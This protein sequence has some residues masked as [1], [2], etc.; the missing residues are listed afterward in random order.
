MVLCCCLHQKHMKCQ[1]SVR[2]GSCVFCNII[3]CEMSG[4][5]TDRALCCLP[6][7]IN[8]GRASELTCEML[9]NYTDRVLCCLDLHQKYV[10]CLGIARTG[11]YDLLT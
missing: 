10:K 9:V 5:Y 4:N 3:L 11:Y 2:T 7:I 6:Y 1:G 8:I